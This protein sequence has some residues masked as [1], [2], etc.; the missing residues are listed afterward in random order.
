MFTSNVYRSAELMNDGA[1]ALLPLYAFM[2]WK[3]GNIAF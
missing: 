1:E 2:A 3:G